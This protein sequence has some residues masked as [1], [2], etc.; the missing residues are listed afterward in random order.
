[1]TPIVSH[2]RVFLAG[3]GFSGVSD[4]ENLTRSEQDEFRAQ[5]CTFHG[6]DVNAFPTCFFMPE[7]LPVKLWALLQVGKIKADLGMAVAGIEE[8]V[9]DPA[10]FL[11]PEAPAAEEAPEPVE[12]TQE[13]E[14]PKE[15]T[16]PEAPAAEEAPEPVE[17]TQEPEAPKEETP[18]EAP[19]T[20]DTP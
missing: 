3:V 13:P 19:E 10:A 11:Q 17:E 7:L 15:E 1:M 5:A 2:V 20:L 9:A 4:E 18:P 16:P 8:F 12:E 6:A 14:A